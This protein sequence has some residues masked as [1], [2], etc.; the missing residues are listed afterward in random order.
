[1]TSVAPFPVASAVSIRAP[2]SPSGWRASA[3]PKRERIDA[4][5]ATVSTGAA[6]SV[7]GPTPALHAVAT[8]C[9]ISRDANAAAPS[10]PS[11][12]MR[13]VFAN[14]GI[15]ALASTAT[16][17]DSLAIAVSPRQQRGVGAQEIGQP[18][19]PHQ[20]DGPQ[21]AVLF[22]AP[23]R[24]GDAFGEAERRADAL[25]PLAQ[26]NVLHQRDGRKAAGC[27]KHLALD[28]YRLVASGDPSHAR[29]DVHG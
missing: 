7:T 29:A 21:H 22:P 23:A 14:P 16:A 6:H 28:E 18:Q 2:R 9:S 27:D 10:A 15:G 8:A 24:G 25:E 11:A 4:K 17:T 20:Q 13:R 3:M 12:G 26:R 19:A 1:M 5:A